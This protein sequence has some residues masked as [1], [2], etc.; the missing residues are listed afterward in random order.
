[1]NQPQAQEPVALPF[2]LGQ[3]EPEI[4]VILASVIGF[5]AKHAVMPA[6]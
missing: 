6:N 1:M 2:A 3:A 5:R 4:G